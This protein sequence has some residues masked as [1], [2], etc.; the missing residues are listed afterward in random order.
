VTGAGPNTGRGIIM[1]LSKAGAAVAVS[2]L[3]PEHADA[4]RD[5]ILNADGHAISVPFDVTDF[6]AVRAG[7][8]NA[9][10]QLGPITIL[11]N[12]AGTI[13]NPQPGFTGGQLGPFEGSD[14]WMW[15]RW[16]DINLY[17]AMQCIHSTLPDMTARGRGRIIQ[18]SSTSGS[19]GLAGGSVYG[20]SKAG[21]EGFLRG[22]A[23]EVA[24]RGVTVNTLALGTMEMIDKVDNER[25]RAGLRQ[26][27][28]GRRGRGREVGA[29]A[30]WLASDAGEWITGQTI[31]LNGG[32]FQGR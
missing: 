3:N 6:D 7:V 23:M 5:S 4:G 8:S 17:G 32:T 16:I 22:L 18:I 30:V 14:P 13:A 9:R 10:D 27:P 28:L 11:V 26:V 29:A 31:H 21:I 1:A 15:R 2:D 19:R 12:N 20:A 24:P 25:T